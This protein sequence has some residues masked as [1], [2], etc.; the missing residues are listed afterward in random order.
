M[1]IKKEVLTDYINKVSLGGAIPTLNLD[2][3]VDG[4]TTR[5]MN[6]GTTAMVLGALKKE[7]FTEY[8]ALGELFIKDST[9][10]LNALKTFSD[11]ITVERGTDVTLRLSTSDREVN[12]ML[13]EEKICP[14]LFRDKRP[15]IKPTTFVVADKS[16]LN[17][18]LNDMKLLNVGSVTFTKVGKELTISIGNENE[19]DFIKNV[20]VCEEEGDAVVSVAAYF[21]EA[22]SSMSDEITL[23]LGTDMPVIIDDKTE[24][25]ETETFLSPLIKFED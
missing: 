7:A 3:G 24:F 23:H 6:T 17:L 2:F 8:E 5:V 10:L 19:H 11:E 4:I 18:T 15:D 9:M 13:A 12:I 14:N 20:L 25:I 1:K 22:V 21:K 16:L